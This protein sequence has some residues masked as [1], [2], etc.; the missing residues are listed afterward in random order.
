[1]PIFRR[2][3]LDDAGQDLIEYALLAAFIG[4]VSILVWNAI[5]AG[6]G[7]DYIGWDGAV[8]GL[9]TTTP[10]PAGAGS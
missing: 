6:I 7:A 10:D 2:L 5:A 4:T 3:L 9:S 8:Q 1:M